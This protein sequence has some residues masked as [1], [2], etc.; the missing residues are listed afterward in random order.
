V[1]RICWNSPKSGVAAALAE[2]GARQW[3]IEIVAPIL[4]LAL[5]E[6]TPVVEEI[7][8]SDAPESIES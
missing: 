2:L 1:R 7:E 6:T 8:N 5:L 3:Q 4:E